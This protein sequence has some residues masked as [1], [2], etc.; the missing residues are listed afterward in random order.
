MTQSKLICLLAALAI[1]TTLSAQQLRVAYFGET[2]THYGVKAG[3]QHSLWQQSIPKED[4]LFAQKSLLA[5]LSLILYRHPKNHVGLI[6]APEIGYQH[7]GK[8][9]GMVEVA[10]S[11]SL[12][13]TFLEGKTYEVGANG[14]LEKLSLAGRWAFLPTVSLGFGR[15][16]SVKHDLPITWYARANI[17]QQRPYN[18]SA[19]LRF[20]IEA[21]IITPLK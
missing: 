21:G 11:P 13:R 17:M 2:V 15:D 8:K 18:D 9:G 10:V 14:D 6:L 5:N 4:G 3:Y 7:I 1:T 16:L 20:G 19:L 12:F